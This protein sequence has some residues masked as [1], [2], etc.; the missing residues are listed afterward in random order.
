MRRSAARL[1]LAAALVAILAGCQAGAE[2][3]GIAVG[4]ASGAATANPAVGF[5]VGV[6]T[7]V[8]A[9]QAF[10]WFGR[11]REHAEQQAIADA[12]AA[13]PEGGA[14]PWRIRHD[15]PIGDE[16]GE[17]RVVSVMI[18][19]LAECRQILFSV[20]DP[21]AAPV[22]YATSIC[23]AQDGWHWGLAEPAVARWGFMQQ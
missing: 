21:P 15:I 11:T 20:V 4:G 19:S 13:L 10:K 18:T 17:V 3:T 7:A 2:L 16:S 5:A 6:G 8:V 14:G 12:A 23:H 1:A 22:W 9:D